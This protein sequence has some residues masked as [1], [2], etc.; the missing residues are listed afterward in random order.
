MLA[1]ATVIFCELIRR[2][3]QDTKLK[4]MAVI[5]TSSVFIALLFFGYGFLFGF[6]SG[7]GYGL[8]LFIASSITERKRLGFA[9]GLVTASYAFGAVVFSMLYPFL[10]RYFGLKKH[11]IMSKLL[12]VI[13]GI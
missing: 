3:T 10:F 12:F 11:E 2:R 1:V 7:L 13:A 5:L 8:S 6:S 9:L 4:T